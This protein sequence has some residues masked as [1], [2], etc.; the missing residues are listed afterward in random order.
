MRV[1]AQV[2]ASRESCGKN[3][4]S[5]SSTLAQWLMLHFT[6]TAQRLA[7]AA[8]EE[9]LPLEDLQKL[10]ACLVALR[11]GDHAREW[12]ELERERLKLA[13][14]SSKERMEAKFEKWVLRPE[15]QERFRP[16]KMTPEEKE[17]AMKA[18]FGITD[19]P[20]VDSR[21][22]TSAQKAA[23]AKK[24]EAGLQAMPPVQKTGPEEPPLEGAAPPAVPA[25]SEA[26]GSLSNRSVVA[27]GTNGGR[28]AGEPAPTLKRETDGCG[29]QSSNE[30]APPPPPK[31]APAIP[32]A[33]PNWPTMPSAP[34]V[35]GVPYHFSSVG[36][37]PY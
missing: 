26:E 24:A 34:L 18:V 4:E 32:S 3:A 23:D 30:P 21:W 5:L 28:R 2:D 36:P 17:R 22:R 12:M 20:P 31:K 16:K 7:E 11:K 15:V 37:F 33:G 35:P 10:T 14:E 1:R 13:Q 9:G 8:G 27:D 6:V 19:D 25:L 29:N